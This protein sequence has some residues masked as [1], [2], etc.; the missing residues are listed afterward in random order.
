M[1]LINKTPPVSSR[2]SP[3]EAVAPK[4]QQHSDTAHQ[5]S[6]SQDSSYAYPIDYHCRQQAPGAPSGWTVT[7]H[8]WSDA[9]LLGH[10]ANEKDLMLDLLDSGVG[11]QPGNQLAEELKGL[12]YKISRLE[13][14]EG[15]AA[16][17]NHLSAALVERGAGAI[18]GGHGVSEYLSQVIGFCESGQSN[19]SSSDDVADAFFKNAKPDEVQSYVAD[20]VGTLNMIAA[21]GLPVDELIAQCK[22][23]LRR[24][25]LMKD[26]LSKVALIRQVL[27]WAEGCADVDPACFGRLLVEVADEAAQ[28]VQNKAGGDASGG[29]DP[30]HLADGTRLWSS[31]S[32]GPTQADLLQIIYGTG[33]AL[34]RALDAHVDGHPSG[35][36]PPDAELRVAF[37]RLLQVIARLDDAHVRNQNYAQL[38]EKLMRVTHNPVL[39]K[40]FLVSLAKKWD[41]EGPIASV[42]RPARVGGLDSVS[43]LVRD[44][45]EIEGLVDDLVAQELFRGLT[46]TSEGYVEHT[47]RDDAAGQWTKPDAS[48][49]AAY[50]T[51][52]GG[53]TLQT[54]QAI[55]AAGKA[56]MPLLWGF[57]IFDPAQGLLAKEINT[58]KAYAAMARSLKISVK[59]PLVLA[60]IHAQHNKIPPEIY[61][62]YYR[63]VARVAQELGVETIRLGAIYQKLNLTLEQVE[64][65]GPE[66]VQKPGVISRQSA[67]TAAIELPRDYWTHLK[68]QAKHT[69]ARFPGVLQAP[70]GYRPAEKFYGDKALHYAQFRA[71][72]GVHVL[73]RL[74]ELGEA[75]GAP[76]L[77]VHIADPHSSLVGVNGLYIHAKDDANHTVAAIPWRATETPGRGANE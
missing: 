28:A 63:E 16:Q 30:R 61:E 1:K 58:I 31:R 40:E 27:D 10:I 44:N 39:A 13:G 17:L 38:N 62:P 5:A 65:R 47:V 76:V 57:R 7:M 51:M 8:Y 53:H 59:A 4:S 77:P 33:S 55:Q 37:G 19:S 54:L 20:E 66:L 71:S 45:P 69:V 25:N 73:P 48:Q 64:G 52:D 35:Q 26:P 46:T 6:T 75:N 24:I 49:T 22:T 68:V 11:L 60:D 21:Q 23:L 74:V 2:R 34:L 70:A 15:R 72:E 36:V 32:S 41:V 67:L 12:I 56:F 50:R 29:M 18:I 9:M 42:A 43:S 3:L 14:R